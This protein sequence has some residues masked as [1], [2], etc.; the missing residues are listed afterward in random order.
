MNLLSNITDLFFLFFNI[1]LATGCWLLAAG[2]WQLATGLRQFYS[3]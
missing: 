1:M 3:I 2:N